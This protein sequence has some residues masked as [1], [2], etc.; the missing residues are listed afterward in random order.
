M[1]ST[2]P[3]NAAPAVSQYQPLAEWLRSKDS[4]LK[5]TESIIMNFGRRVECFHGQQILDAVMNAN[6]SHFPALKTYASATRDEVIE[7]FD[8][9]I[10]DQFFVR[11]VPI[12]EQT[13]LTK[14]A[15]AAAA[16]A[17]QQD[18]PQ[19]LRVQLDSEK[20]FDV[21]AVFMWTYEVKSSV[22]LVKALGTIAFII[23]VCCFKIW[24]VWMRIVVWWLSMILLSTF[25]IF[26]CPHVSL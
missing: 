7:V 14:K 8:K 2:S 4:R 22:P 3:V 26:T 12:I 5:W 9:M 13:T 1:S 10:A 16:A 19:E 11:V 17:G 20:T 18:T 24:P 6:V 25:T 23:F 21:D 15:A